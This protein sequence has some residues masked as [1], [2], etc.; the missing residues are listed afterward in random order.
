MSILDKSNPEFDFLK[1]KNGKIER[2][3]SKRIHDVLSQGLVTEVN[4]VKYYG[5]D[6]AKLKEGDD[7]SEL[8][9]VKKFV[10]KE[11]AASYTSAKLGE[12]FPDYLPKTDEEAIQNIPKTL[13]K[14]VGEEVVVTRK[15]D[16][17]LC[18]YNVHIEEHRAHMY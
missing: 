6:P 3:K 2:L 5:A 7:V 12:P 16:G 11:E 17:T 10:K 13:C 18:R 1:N 14:L 8:L 9:K 15:E 4:V